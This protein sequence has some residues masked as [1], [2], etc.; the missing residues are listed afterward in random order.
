MNFKTLPTAGKGTRRFQVL[1]FF[2]SVISVSLCLFSQSSLLFE[3]EVQCIENPPPTHIEKPEHYAAL[4]KVGEI[5]ADIDDEHFM[6]MPWQFTGNK[7]GDIYIFDIRLQ[8]IF[9]FD[10]NMKFVAVFGNTGQGPGEFSSRRGGGLKEMYFGYDDS[11]YVSDMGNNKIINF[12]ANGKHARDI[13]L[14]VPAI[15][16]GGFF[17][18]I[19]PNGNFFIRTGLNCSIDAYNIND[20]QMKKQYSLLSLKDFQRSVI[21]KV[22]KQE[23]LGWMFSEPLAVQY[24]LIPE[25]RLMV[26]LATTSTVFIFRGDRLE[27]TFN[28]WPKKVLDI[29][30]KEIEKRGQKLKKNDSF[31]IFMFLN[32]FLDKDNENCFYLEGRTDGSDKKRFLY[33]FDLN[34]NLVKVLYLPVI[35]RFAFKKNN[36]F[37]TV[38]DDMIYIF[39]E[40]NKGKKAF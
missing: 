10:K 11:L 13:R 19:M 36:L 2:L 14:P 39:K 24:D 29:Y 27:K 22:R 25:N 20:W 15:A 37:Y 16:T 38:A 17:P 18:V 12:T 30:R 1:V 21:L 32:F 7:Q 35:A 28:I 5:A 23:Y 34:G 8:Q 6:V 26:Y 33:Q 31:S 40:K 4:E 9:K 3:G